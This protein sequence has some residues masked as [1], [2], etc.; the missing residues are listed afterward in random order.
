MKINIAARLK[1]LIP[2]LLV[3]TSQQMLFSQDND[4]IPGK[5]LFA[6][7]SL[8]P[9]QT[10]IKN[11]GSSSVTGIASGKV[12]SF[13]ASAEVG[14][15]FSRHFG[16]SSGIGFSTF[17]TPVTLDTYQ[18]HF[19]TI[20]SEGDTYEMRVS[21]T[22]MKEDQKISYLTIPLC[23]DIRL[24]L[25]GKI[26][27]FLQTGLETSIA[28]NNSYSGSGTFTYQGYYPKYNVLLYN[29]PAFGFPTNKDITTTGTLDISPITLFAS[30]SAGFDLFIS[31]NMQLALAAT[32]NKS[33]S[34]VSAYPA[35]ENFQL[36]ESADQVNSFMGGCSSV[37][38]QAV[39]LSLKIRF[40]F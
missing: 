39:G 27:F 18:N 7:I 5:G 28:V 35:T 20:D 9:S 33:L 17:R 8:G 13:E 22:G 4:S 15:F 34:K 31:R 12:T 10:R 36:T 1:L 23:L 30:A 24:P 2:F 37:D 16:L 19:N 40:Y 26:G 21:G 32:Y 38:A 11:V 6:G 25:N 3:I 29:L 14:Y